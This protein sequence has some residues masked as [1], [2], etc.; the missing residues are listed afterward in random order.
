MARAVPG[1]F[2]REGDQGGSSPDQQLAEALYTNGH[3]TVLDKVVQVAL[4]VKVDVGYSKPQI[5]VMCAL[6]VYFGRT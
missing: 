5:G 1:G 6:S 2:R 4:A 3:R